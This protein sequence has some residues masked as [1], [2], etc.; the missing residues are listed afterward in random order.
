M[1][2]FGFITCLRYGKGMENILM[3]THYD[4]VTPDG[5]IRELKRQP[6]GSLFAH[7]SIHN[8]SP[9]FRGFAIEPERVFFNFKST[10]AQLGLNGIAQSIE[11]NKKTRSADISLHIT[12]IGPIA[13]AMLPLIEAGAY[14]GKLF[15]ADEKRRVRDPDYLG[16]FFGR[17]DRHGRPLLSLGGLQGSSDLILEKVEGRAIAYLT[18]KEGT[19]HYDPNIYGFLPSLATALKHPAIK[20]RELLQL[21]QHPSQNGERR[22][23]QEDILLVRTLPLHIR[24][25]FGHVVNE[26]LPKGILHTSASI[27]DPA[28]YESGDVYELFGASTKELSDIPLEFYTLEPYREHVFFADRDQ[29]QN[30]LEN[31]GILFNAFNNTT[32]TPHHPCATFVVKGEQL[33]NL[34]PSHWIDKEPQPQEFPGLIHPGRQALMAER[35][36]HEQPSYPFLKAIEEDKITSQGILLMRYFPSPLMKKLLL[37]DAVQSCLKGIYFQIPSRSYGEFFSHE[38]RSLLLDLAK[39]AIPVFW[40]DERTQKVL[41]YVPRPEKDVGMFVPPS[42]IETFLNA[43]AFGIYGS[44]LLKVD[45]EAE[46]TALMEGVLEI[47]EHTFH[48]LLNK[49]KP[50][51]L[52]TGGGPGVMELGN[53]IAQ[54]LGILSCANIADFRPKPKT[55]LNEQQQNPFIE[56][57][58]TYR[59][60]R[61]VERQGEFNL[62]FPI[63]L[64]GGIG[65]DFE[66]TLEELRRKTGSGEITPILLFGDPNYWQQKITTRFQ[67]NLA[68]GTISGSEWVSNCFYCVQTA[69]DALKIYSRFFEGKLPI[70]KEGPVYKEG[71][72]LLP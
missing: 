39:F 61:L 67:C 31:P 45:S 6:D 55:Y 7:V 4:L 69:S 51:M 68:S 24:T 12:G 34:K 58:M 5:S 32:P 28:T 35:Y 65:T 38:D 54:S 26:L 27:L 60:D 48:P 33:L 1:Q 36:I 41:Q 50:I 57:K 37:S 13:Q 10:L 66:F 63:F 23:K 17:A 70:G 30:C 22:A 42:K 49:K 40:V 62:D 3:A 11:L 19:L 16:R 9:L 18:L 14:V 43:T 25:V 15:A 8:I 20:T 21:H 2:N 56:A 59:I 72:A 53:C 64:M 29:L 46:L 52:V 44:N 47:R 71:F